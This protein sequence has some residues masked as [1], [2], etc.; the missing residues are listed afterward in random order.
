MRLAEERSV[1]RKLDQNG[2]ALLVVR[3]LL[4]GYFVYMGVSKVRDPVEFLKLIRLYEMMPE[5]PAVFMNASAIVV[6]WLEIIAGSALVLGLFAGGAAA[7]IATMLTV[8]TPAIFLRA[9]AIR[10]SEGTGF[11]DIAFDCGCG[12]GVVIIW[13]KLLEN[14]LLL[15][16]AILLMLSRSRRFCLDRVLDGR[17][18]RSTYCRACGYGL[19][20]GVDGV[21]ATCRDSA[22]VA[23]GAAEPAG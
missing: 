21:C 19:C 12:S 18:T 17:R 7:T 3:V 4:G 5:S 20:D 1:I 10:A 22:Q 13:K 11:F 9:L 2:L 23:A 8:F 15:L 16:A 14:A 6:P